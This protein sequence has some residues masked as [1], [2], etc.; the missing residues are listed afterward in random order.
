MA[1]ST[2]RE[3]VALILTAPEHA[4]LFKSENEHFHN[5]LFKQATSFWRL[6]RANSVILS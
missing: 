5:I 6:A 3:A 2:L 4:R 1:S